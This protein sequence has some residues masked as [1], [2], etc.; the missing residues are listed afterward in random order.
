MVAL[1]LHFDYILLSLPVTPDID[2]RGN[3][4]F[5]LPVEHLRPQ[6]L[7]ILQQEE[8]DDGEDER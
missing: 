1:A 5:Y 2:V 8:P 7:V 4:S 3:G 6:G